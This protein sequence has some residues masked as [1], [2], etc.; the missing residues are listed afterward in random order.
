MGHII[1]EN[2][3]EPDPDKVKALVLLTPPGDL[4]QLHT[5]L[6]KTKYLSRLVGSLIYLLSTRHDIA[7][8]TRILC[9][10]MHC[11]IV[12]HGMQP[13]GF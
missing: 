2:G 10:F 13:S 3:I 1:S 7:Y 11:P 9:Q 4:R 8:A 5:F 6:Q 12:T